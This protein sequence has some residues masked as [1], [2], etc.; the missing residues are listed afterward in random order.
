MDKQ[1]EIVQD[2]LP[3]Y[4]D[5][6]CSEASMEMVKEHLPSCS[7]CREIYQRLCSH[8][9]EDVLQQEKGSVVARHE[10]KVKRK[11]ALAIIAA[12]VLTL[13]VVLACIN[14]RPASIDYGNSDVYSKQ[15][16]D[17]AIKM[18]KDRFYSWKGCKLYSISYAGDDFCE[19]ELDYCNTLADAGVTYTECIVFRMR[20]R[21][22]IFGGGAW[23]PNFEYDWSW[24]LARTQGGE[25]EL[26]TWGAP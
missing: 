8:T 13:I 3:L 14:L 2:L 18:I 7:S 4:V 9:N 10:K 23:N 17:E 24:Y 11:K 12:V 16:M 19:R 6:A 15:D 22:P 26:L 25:W 5:G 21:S 20:F 1:C